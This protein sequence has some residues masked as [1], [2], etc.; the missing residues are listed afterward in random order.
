VPPA[1]QII[2]ICMIASL[3]ELDGMA[4]QTE[5]ARRAFSCNFSITQ[6]DAVCTSAGIRLV[7]D[8]LGQA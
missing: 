2:R 6:C 4:V 5:A 1:T 8:A 7:A 3:S